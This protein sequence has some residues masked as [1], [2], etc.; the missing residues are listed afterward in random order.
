MGTE[1]DRAWSTESIDPDDT[2]VLRKPALGLFDPVLDAGLPMF[3]GTG[4]RPDDDAMGDAEAC[5]VGGLE[6]SRKPLLTIS[7]ILSKYT[8]RLRNTSYV[9]GQ[10][11]W[12]LLR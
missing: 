7:V 5:E 9:V 10:Y 4:D 3:I 1:S 6:V 11:L 12:I 2:G 8:R